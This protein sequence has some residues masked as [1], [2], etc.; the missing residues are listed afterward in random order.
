MKLQAI[1]RIRGLKK[2]LT[3]DGKKK[4]VAVPGALYEVDDTVGQMHLTEGYAVLPGETVNTGLKHSGPM[5]TEVEDSEE[6][7]SKIEDIAPRAEKKT[8]GSK[9]TAAAKPQ[10]PEDDDLGLD[11]VE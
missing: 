10:L 8:K 9:K 2:V 1:H 5:V 4:G 3:G 7:A 6:D 11:T